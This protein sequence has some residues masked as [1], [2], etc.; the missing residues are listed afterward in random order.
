MIGMCVADDPSPRSIKR[1]EYEEPIHY[2][3][4]A[5]TEGWPGTGSG[6]L[7]ACSSHLQRVFRVVNKASSCLSHGHIG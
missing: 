4:H 2:Q 7:Q 6:V 5:V 1:L 3:S